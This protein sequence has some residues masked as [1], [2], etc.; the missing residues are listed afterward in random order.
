MG[1][2]GTEERQRLA[3][4]AERR[5]RNVERYRQEWGALTDEEVIAELIPTADHVMAQVAMTHRLNT[6][7]GDLRG[8]LKRAERLTWAL[9]LLSF[10]LL[11]V[12]AVLAF[13]S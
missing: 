7:I 10:G 4:V 13:R 6:S 1:D 11:L 9:V 3:R 8:A 5:T 12:T 2:T